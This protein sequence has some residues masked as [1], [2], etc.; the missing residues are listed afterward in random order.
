MTAKIHTSNVCIVL[1]KLSIDTFCS[2][3]HYTEEFVQLWLHSQLE[4]VP[5]TSQWQVRTC[6]LTFRCV[7]FSETF[8]SWWLFTGHF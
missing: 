3:F 6:M 1:L 2:M 8:E 7:C 5:G 4:D